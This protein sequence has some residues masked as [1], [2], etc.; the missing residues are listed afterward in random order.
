[1][2][3]LISG[4]T[5]D[6]TIDGV[7]VATEPEVDTKVLADKISTGQRKNYLINGNFDMWQRGS[8]VFGN[9]AYIETYTADRWYAYLPNNA[10]IQA[11]NAATDPYMQLSTGTAGLTKVVQRIENLAQFSGKT[12]TLSFDVF[13][14][15]ITTGLAI[16]TNYGTGGSA[17]VSI[18]TQ[19]YTTGGR[20]VATFTVPDI[21]TAKTYG[22]GHY[23]SIAIINDSS[24]FSKVIGFDKIKLEDGSV[25]TDGW[26]P[27][28]GEFGGEVQACERYL[29]SFECSEE[30]DIIGLG[31]CAN[32]TVALY[33]LSYMTTPRVIPTGII[34]TG[35]FYSAAANT[36]AN[37]A[38]LSIH[39]TTSKNIGSVLATTSGLVSGNATA[40][41]G[42]VGAKILFTGCEL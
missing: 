25:A 19:S 32:A 31:Q 8:G 4:E 20:V 26:H 34:A 16:E 1:M 35:S 39:S 11:T 30:Y 18:Y 13:G 21:I 12:L 15:S 42:L 17:G 29:P 37:P 24:N 10:N 6:I 27:Y 23:L 3:I 2:G 14:A 22:A 28:D 33:N 7:S 5:N 40:L 38:T 41:S 36:S 9:V